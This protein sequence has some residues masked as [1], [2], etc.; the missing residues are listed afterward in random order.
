MSISR[1]AHPDCGGRLGLGV[2]SAKVWVWQK[3]WLQ[4]YRFCSIRCRDRF[5]KAR[6]D[7]RV[8]RTAVAGL[9]HPP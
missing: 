4:V 1:C 7:E 8:R 5:L 9:F 2:V 3:Y 6:A